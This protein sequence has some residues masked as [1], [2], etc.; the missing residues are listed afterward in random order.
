[1]LGEGEDNSRGLGLLLD[2]QGS[3]VEHLEVAVLV[4][5]MVSGVKL[6]R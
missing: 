4:V 3:G 2:K 6:H 1:M 5:I